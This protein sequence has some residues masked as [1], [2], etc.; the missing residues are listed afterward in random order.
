MAIIPPLAAQPIPSSG[1]LAFFVAAG[2]T[3]AVAS[4]S[5]WLI[6]RPFLRKQHHGH[7]SLVLRNNQ[8]RRRFAGEH[9]KPDSKTDSN[10]D[11]HQ[12]SPVDSDEH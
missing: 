8:Q 9:M 1:M 4:T 3:L 2:A 5:Y 11:E 10:R 12:R 7:S 6:E